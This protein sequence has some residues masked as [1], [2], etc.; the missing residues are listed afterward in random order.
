MSNT[1]LDNSNIIETNNDACRCKLY[2]IE[3]G[4][5]TDPYLK[6]LAGSAPQERRTPE[7]SLGYYV[8]VHGLRHLIGKF[9]QLTN[10]QCQIVN[11]G[12]GFD[13]TI[14]YLLDHEHLRFITLSMWISTKSP[15]SNLQRF[16]VWHH[17]EQTSPPKTNP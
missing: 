13:T 11:L 2:A 12:C 10:H 3:R 15:R 9:I 7:I 8:R 1:A 5:W 6:L 16:V 14:F 4:Y 17:R